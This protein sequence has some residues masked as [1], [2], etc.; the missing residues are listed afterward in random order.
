MRIHGRQLA[1]ARVLL[2][3]TQAQVAVAT[4]LSIP[5]IRRMEASPGEIVGLANNI[6]AIQ[7]YLENLGVEFILNGGDRLGV[8][9][10]I[11][12]ADV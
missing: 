12:T 7:G 2:G 3:L 10:R 1:A 4:S 11:T 9:L 8:I 5:T 6:K